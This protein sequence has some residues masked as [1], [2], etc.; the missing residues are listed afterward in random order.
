MASSA[1]MNYQS[2]QHPNDEPDSSHHGP[3]ANFNQ[4]DSEYYSSYPTNYAPVSTVFPDTNPQNY[5]GGNR[6][7]EHLYA[8]TMTI[9]H[10]R[11]STAA[12]TISSSDTAAPLLFIYHDGHHRQIFLFDSHHY[13]L[14][15][16]SQ[17]SSGFM[18]SGKM[19]C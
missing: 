5:G 19:T 6:Q 12:T 17:G 1:F 11:Q 4:D 10:D 7:H 3:T 2:D 14:R 15:F 18:E 13:L 16:G 9:T 8:S